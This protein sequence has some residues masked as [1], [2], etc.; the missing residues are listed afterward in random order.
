MEEIPKECTAIS[1]ALRLSLDTNKLE[2][3]PES[4]YAPKLVSLLLGGNPIQFVPESFLV[5]FPKLRVPEELGKLK[6]FICLELSDC[7]NLQILPDAVGKL[8]VLKCLS[9]CD[10]RMLNYLPSGVVGLTSLQVLCTA[11]CYNLAW[12]EHTPSG[13]ARAESLGHVYPTIGA[14]LEDICGLVAL[15][16]LC[17]SGETD[18][19]VELPH[20]ISALMKLK[21]L[22]LDLNVKTLPAEMP[23]WFIRGPQK[24][25]ISSKVLHM[26]W[27]FS[28]SYKFS[29][30][31]SEAC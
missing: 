12:A 21:V 8:H 14:S 15:T 18:P 31:C 17:I 30:K 23:H 16:E 24:F 22:Q 29:T 25:G 1:E 6:D 26:S 28:S 9:L 5:N 10:C 2:K 19:V 3:L 27:C 4:F 7:D 13:M 11:L 20:N